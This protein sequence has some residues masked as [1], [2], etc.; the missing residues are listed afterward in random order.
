MTNLIK[1]V[2]LIKGKELKERKISDRKAYKSVKTQINMANIT[3]AIPDSLHKRLRKHSE[4][5]W[6]EVIRKILEKKLEDLKIM[7]EIVENSKF[8]LGDVEDIGDKIKLGIA[9]RHGL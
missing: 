3:L 6:S 9:K 1:F 7:D 2:F 4:V 8:S 5:R